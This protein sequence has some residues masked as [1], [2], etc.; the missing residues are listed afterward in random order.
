MQNINI[1][2]WNIDHFDTLMDLQ[3]ELINYMNQ[4]YDQDITINYYELDETK[5]LYKNYLTES[6]SLVLF[7]KDVSSNEII[8]HLNGYLYPY[9][10]KF[11]GGI[12]SYLD[13]VYIRDSYRSQGIWK[14]LMKQF[15]LR[16]KEQWCDH[17]RLL[18]DI[19]NTE[20]VELY[21]ELNLS[22]G[23]AFMDWKI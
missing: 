15:T 17:M 2:R 5:Q 9:L 10:S 7:V 21:K 20:A 12:W 14:E 3:K 8:W 16:S 4:K 11:R 22:A 23:Y 6:R 1:Y 19:K 13:S 18:V